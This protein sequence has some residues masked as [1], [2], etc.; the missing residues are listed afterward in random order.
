VNHYGP[1]ESSVVATCTAVEAGE[2]SDPPIGR[3]IDNTRTYVLDADLNPAPVGVAGELYIGGEGLARGYLGA[4]GLT[5]ERFVPDP[6]GA[7]PGGRLYRTGD[8]VRY[9]PDGN[10]EFLGRID[11]QVKLR[12]FRVEL[13]EIESVLGQHP[14]VKGAV[15][16]ARPEG[17]WPAS[18]G[19]RGPRSAGAGLG[20]GS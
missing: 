18:G 5:A 4:P 2:G 20:R 16:V 8:L 11:H 9:R 17:I 6:F 7:E 13:G 15:V 19:V 1:T 10:L 3:P 14:E 12:G